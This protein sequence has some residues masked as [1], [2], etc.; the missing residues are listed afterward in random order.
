M[1]LYLCEKPSQGRDIGRVLGATARRQGYMEGAGVRVTWCIGHLLEMIAP[2]SYTPAWKSW[3]IDTLP[4]VPATWKLQ[5]TR[6]GS[7][8]YKIIQNL[9]KGV[10]EVVLATDADREG[11][12][13]GREVLERCRYRGKISRLWLSALDDAS[14][15]KALASLWPGEKT[16]PLYQAGL[17][18]S[19]ADWLVGMNLTRAYTIMGRQGGY[20]GVLSVGRVQTPT[21]KLV[22][23]RDRQIEQFKPLDFFD[24]IAHH[25]VTNGTFKAKW[26]PPKKHAD[27]EGR[28]LDRQVAEA[29]VQRVHGQEGSVTKAGTKRVKV[30]APLPLELSTLQQEASRKL[31]FSAKKTMMVA[32]RL[33]E[34]TE[35][36]SIEGGLITYMRTD[37]VTL[38][39]EAID[40]LRGQIE[41]RYGPDYLPKSPR[42][43][44]SSSKNA[45]E[46]HEAIRPTDPH[47]T[48]DQVKHALTKD[49]F[50][51][52]ELIWKRSMAC[53][54][55][56]AR[57]DKVAATIGVDS[58]DPKAP[59]QLRANGSSVAFQGF[60]KVYSEGRDE[61]SAQDRD[62]ESGLLPMLEQ[63]EELTQKGIQ[64]KQHFTEPKPRYTEATLVKA[65]ESYGIGRPS[66]YAPTMSTLQ[67]RGY[68]RLETRKFFPEDVGMVVN[69]FL[70]QHFEKYVDYH[71][72]AHLED[73]LDAVS[74]GEKTW[75]PLLGEFWTPFIER[76]QEKDKT[77]NKAD[78]TT[79]ATDE[80]CPE[81]EKPLVIK[82]GRYGRFKACTGYPECRFTQDLR[83]KEGDGEAKE[84]PEVSDR[85][86]GKCG[87]AMLIKTGRFG[88]YLACSGYPDCKN[89]EP[90]EKPKDTGVVCIECGKANFMEKKSRRGKIFYSCARY[91]D[92][93]KALWDKPLKQPCP[94]CGAPF[95]T[96]KITKRRG[97]EH[98]CVVESCDYLE[99]VVPPEKPAAKPA[100]RKKAPAKKAAT[101]KAAAKKT[102]TRKTAAKKT[103]TR[104]PAAKKT[105][106]KTAAK[107]STTRKTTATKTAA[108][109]SATRKT[110]ASKAAA[111]KKSAA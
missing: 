60:M 69:G 7:Q 17:G 79:Q 14:I 110:A 68:V 44:K 18:R 31:G 65:L 105:A 23:D 16:Q 71:F 3:R 100:A 85:K 34:G 106:S 67:D 73:D 9:L 78:V 39:Q 12:T 83:Q 90:L 41:Q 50:R 55:S 29:V 101:R 4:M 93:K 102:T 8:Q 82:L 28:C 86:C 107:K 64:P 32:Q 54:M 21:L 13:I 76:V 74:R 26:I 25:R 1:I 58:V 48:P 62:E 10:H 89:I 81:C 98:I 5:L 30:P 94:K 20:Q 53:Q 22:V 88:K 91:P 27:E 108:K 75:K 109:K 96:E 77:T 99:V 2:D 42:K 35:D 66:T 47:R 43:F 49:M 19:R 104:K 57:I 37:S 97:T 38:A 36:S 92:C 80:K 95:V 24:V 33:Y 72:T 45:Q 6:R 70:T 63:N 15:R 52:Y 61:V 56:A 59:Y 51:L 46:A 103:T 111:N 84:E 87:S 40:A 11:E